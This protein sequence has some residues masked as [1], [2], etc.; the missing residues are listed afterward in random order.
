M[1][2]TFNLG[3]VPKWYIA[4]LVGKPLGAG[5]LVAF[6]NLD[7]TSVNLIFQDP[8]GL[9]PWPLV[10]VP[11]QAFNGILFDENGSQGPFYFAFNTT[12]PAIIYYL[13]V[14][15]KNGILQ[16]TMDDYIPPSGTG[17]SIITDTSNLNNIV[18][19]SPMW[20][21]FN[22]N[23]LNT[24]STTAPAVNPASPFIVAPSAHAGFAH[25]PAANPA[26]SGL[27][28]GSDIVF[29]KNSVGESDTLSFVLFPTGVK[30]LPT[31]VTPLGYLNYTCT[32]AAAGTIKCIQ[33]PICRNVSNL[34]Q[35]PV[36]ISFWARG[37]SGSTTFNLAFW[38]FFGDGV[39]TGPALSV[40]NSFN[41]TPA[42]AFYTFSIAV[43]S[44]IGKTLGL[45]DNDALFLQF[46]YPNNATTNIDFTLPRMYLGNV[47]L[48]SDY[49]SS[50]VIDGL[51]NAPRTGNVKGVY[52]PLGITTQYGWVAMNDG[53]IG[54]SGSGATI[55]ANSNAYALYNF[56]YQNVSDTWAPVTGGRSGNSATDFTAGK[57]MALPKALGRA[58]CEAGLASGGSTTWALGQN[59]GTE[60]QSVILVP[61][62]LP[63]H[64][65]SSSDGANFLTSNAGSGFR[66]GSGGQTI[67]QSNSTT[68]NN[69]TTN[70]PITFGVF[71]PSTFMT[72]LIKL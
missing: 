16:W 2:I 17:G 70:A 12:T 7:H 47:A 11:N 54:Q 20:R 39:A 71:Q 5:Y 63:P 27:Y 33:V 35:I 28:T 49:Q 25:N 55:Y 32:S 30:T 40:V 9:E 72:F 4:D 29:L 34:S 13:E 37:N 3:F 66:Y 65:H 44:T 21:M 36:T 14:Y 23:N 64:V 58:M 8:A 53:T 1:A 62:N 43:P 24:A 48:M 51:I 52:D 19:N 38:Q 18:V 50:D 22:Q 31:D 45:C 46:Q 56:L 59:G 15:D 6:S 41:L 67:S 68:G 10:P 42:W 60:S 69:A 26:S 61:N 57:V